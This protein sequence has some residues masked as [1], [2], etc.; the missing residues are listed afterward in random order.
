MPW[1]D[2]P[3]P[4]GDDRGGGGRER[5]ANHVGGQ[6]TPDRATSTKLSGRTGG[7]TEHA[8]PLSMRHRATRSRVKGLG[9]DSRGIRGCAT[10]S[11]FMASRQAHRSWPPVLLLPAHPRAASG[12]GP[13]ITGG[14]ILQRHEK[15]SALAIL[16][17]PRTCP[18][19]SCSPGSTR[20]VDSIHVSSS[21][22]AL[23]GVPRRKGNSTGSTPGF[24]YQEAF[25]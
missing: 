6:G 3:D 12:V 1:I 20:T 9:R 5:T 19:R 15:N 11:F 18:C 17:R 21:C 14:V 13:V 8:P 25:I 2:H 23:D 22:P 7:R 10:A 4:V 16:P 24:Y